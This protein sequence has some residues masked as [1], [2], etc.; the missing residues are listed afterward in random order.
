MNRTPL[1]NRAWLIAIAA[2]ALFGLAGLVHAG[3]ERGPSAERIVALAAHKLD[4]SSEQQD[5]L[6]PL[7]DEALALH[8]DAR[9]ARELMQAASREELSRADADLQALA[10]ERQAQTDRRL[11]QA[12]Q[13]RDRFLRY[14]QIELS[15]AQQASA[16]AAMLERMDRFQQLRGRMQQRRDGLLQM[17]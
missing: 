3:A 2:A 9:K 16:R 4:L 8:R 14:Y 6:R 1:R 15:P 11:Q 10:L 5:R 12:R 17:Q 13:L 7:V